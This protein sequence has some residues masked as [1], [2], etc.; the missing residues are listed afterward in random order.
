MVLVIRG[1]F[2]LWSRH[3][4]IAIPD[5]CSHLCCI[6]SSRRDTTPSLVLM[7]LCSLVIS[8]IRFP[9]MDRQ[10]CM[11]LILCEVD[12][13]KT[14]ELQSPHFLFS[15]IVAPT[16]HLPRWNA[17]CAMSLHSVLHAVGV[18]SICHFRFGVDSST[19]I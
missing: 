9:F 11:R 19:H 12:F 8:R 18:E 4:Y 10:S 6:A 13:R 14:R 7:L 5:Y 2:P 3:S 17:C 1:A 15:F 16:Y